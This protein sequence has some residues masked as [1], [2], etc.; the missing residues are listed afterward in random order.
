LISHHIRPR[1]IGVTLIGELVQ[2]FP[3]IYDVVRDLA[4]SS[5][6]QKRFAAICALYDDRFDYDFTVEIVRKAINDRSVKVREF[7]V[8]RAYTRALNPLLPDLIERTKIEENKTI[9]RYLNN[10]IE[11]ME[12]QV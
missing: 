5:S 11:V 12:Q 10:V 2:Y 4:I 6:G 7:A 8:D 3:Q 1:E 9:L